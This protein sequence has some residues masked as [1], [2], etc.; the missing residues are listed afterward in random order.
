IGT[1][2]INLCW[3]RL[4]QPYVKNDA[5]LRCPSDTGSPKVILPGHGLVI[6]SYVYAGSIGGG[7]CD[8]TPPRALAT[9]TQ[10]SLTVMLT[11]WDNY[12]ASASGWHGCAVNDNESETRWRH[13]G[14]SN[15]L[16]ADGHSQTTHFVNDPGKK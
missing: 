14:H 7:W 1:D 9:I 12:C 8:W 13:N 10:P 2:K 5:L 15:V 16:Y 3:D 11:E 6:R 4:I